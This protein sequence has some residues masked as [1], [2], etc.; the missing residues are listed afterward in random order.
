MEIRLRSN[1]QVITEQQFRTMYLQDSQKP[2]T[3][4]VTLTKAILN[5]LG[6]DPVL[7]APAPAVGEGQVA[8]RD[9][10]IQDKAGNWVTH[11]RVV[12]LDYAVVEAQKAAAIDQKWEAIK[13]ER[14]R[15]ISG[16]VK[17]LINGTERWFHTDIKSKLQHLGNKDTA[18]DQLAA[19]GSMADPVLD[20]DTGAQIVWKTLTPDGTPEVWIPLTCEIVFAIVRACKSLELATH[21]AAVVLKSQMS[22][23]ADPAIYN[24]MQDAANT[25]WPIIFEDVFGIQS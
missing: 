2:R 14:D 10:V 9:G 21:K 18:R 24:F 15:R 22:A 3:L 20:E 23:S 16:G 19:G 7:A 11:W 17:I 1:G 25:K 5:D 8:V 4:A 13:E 6:A 12:S